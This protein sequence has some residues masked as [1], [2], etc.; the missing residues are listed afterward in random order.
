V[1]FFLFVLGSDCTH[2]FRFCG[3][4]RSHPSLKTVRSIDLKEFGKFFLVQEYIHGKSLEEEVGHGRRLNEK[5][6]LNLLEEILEVLKFVHDRDAIHLDLKLANVMRRQLDGKVV[7]IDFGGAKQTSALQITSDGNTK[8]TICVGTLGYM[9]SEQAKGR[10]RPAS[11]VYAVGRIAIRLLTGKEP[12]TIPENPHTGELLWQGLVSEISQDFVKV[13]NKMISDHFKDRYKDASEVLK[14]VQN[15]K[16]KIQPNIPF[17]PPVN[18]P[19]PNTPKVPLKPNPIS[20]NR[21]IQKNSIQWATDLLGFPWKHQIDSLGL[22][23]LGLSLNF[24]LYLILYSLGYFVLGLLGYG[25]MA[26]GVTG[27]TQFALGLILFLVLGVS[28]CGAIPGLRVY[29]YMMAIWPVLIA[30]Q[31]P[32]PSTIILAILLFI[33]IFP[34]SLIVALGKESWKFNNQFIKE[35]LVRSLLALPGIVAGLGLGI[36]LALLR[37]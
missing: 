11:D 6:V 12:Y 34:W 20:P 28:V 14:A 8:L 24:P 3:V 32:S 29:L 1:P 37:R 21:N 17:N 10:P 9:P 26:T 30:W 22:G 2:F 36:L 19:S 23:W 33:L 35:I 31:S 7:L 4:L 15:L 16:A 27:A 5:Q 13:I 18:F 25:L